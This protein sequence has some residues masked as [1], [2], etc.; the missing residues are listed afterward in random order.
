MNSVTVPDNLK[1]SLLGFNSTKDAEAVG[2]I[3]GYLTHELSKLFNLSS[4]DGVTVAYDYPK[5]LKDLDRGYESNHQLTPSEGNVVGIAMTPSVMRD[6]QLKSHIVLSASITEGIQDIAGDKFQR[7]LQTLAHE[8]AHVEINHK[9]DTAFPNTLLCKEYPDERVR[10]KN[11]IALSCWHEYG[12]TRFAAKC[13]QDF[14]SYYEELFLGQL[15][16]IKLLANKSITDYRD[17]NDHLRVLN[18]V[19]E[20]YGKLLKLTAYYLGN[21]SGHGIDPF[22]Q[23]ELNKRISGQ[24]FEPFLQK[25]HDVLQAIYLKYGAWKDQT[26]FEMVADLAEDLLANGGITFH[27]SSDGVLQFHFPH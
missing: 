13:G 10:I 17:H 2:E 12:A 7:F 9:F 8:C 25:L 14:S 15:N 4:L 20:Q 19:V 6:E 27:Y 1:I 3:I 23:E 22:S 16:E 5:A 21:L 18:E 26:Q 24:W 11:N